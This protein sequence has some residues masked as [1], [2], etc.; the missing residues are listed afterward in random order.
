MLCSNF[1]RVNAP[2]Y[3][4]IQEAITR[5]QG[6][7]T[8]LYRNNNPVRSLCSL[9]STYCSSSHRK[10]M[11]SSSSN[12][13][14]GD[15]YV[16]ELISSCNG[17]QDLTKPAGV[18]FKDR[19]HKGFLRA[20]VSLRKPQQL[21]YSPLNFGSS[22]LNANWRNRNP[23]L[24]HGPWLKNLSTSSSACC[25]AGAA[26]DVSFDTTPSDDQLANSPTL[27]NL[28]VIVVLYI[29]NSA[30]ALIVL[31]QHDLDTNTN[32]NTI[33]AYPIYMV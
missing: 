20:G 28:Y 11:A 21:L 27:P 25:L 24:L 26:H 5:Q 18:H 4:R 23:S 3:C 8:S 6:V 33:E 1:L 12:A 31:K 30:S 7:P 13:M 19:T 9:C 22:T 2:I 17:I 29:L 14:L 32:T 16:D 10:P 15:V